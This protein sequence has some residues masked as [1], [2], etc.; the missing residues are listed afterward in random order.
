MMNKSDLLIYPNPTNSSF[1]FQFSLENSGKLIILDLSGKE[2][3]TRKINTAEGLVE[4]NPN[5]ESGIY[6]V[7]F[8]VGNGKTIV[9]KIVIQ[10]I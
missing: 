7:K 2:L 4:I 5:L 6:F 3:F 10:K 8:C 1:F 9:Q